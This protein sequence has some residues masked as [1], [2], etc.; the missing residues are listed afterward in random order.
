MVDK[1]TPVEDMKITLSSGCLKVMGGLTRSGVMKGDEELLTLQAL[2]FD[3]AEKFHC[4]RLLG[5]A[6]KKSAKRV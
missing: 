2:S 6:P 5:V 1:A 3:A 4:R